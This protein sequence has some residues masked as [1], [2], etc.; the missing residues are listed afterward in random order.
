MGEFDL[1]DYDT[2]RGLA[3]KIQQCADDIKR[4]FQDVGEAADS[5]FDENWE[6][7]GSLNA[8]GRYDLIAKNFEPFY[9]KVCE[10]RDYIYK[11]TE[12][13]ETADAEAGGTVQGV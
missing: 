13:Y 12:R 11:A 3:D 9:Q 2:A 5:L 1:K 4:I 7:T 6:S 10:T 8:R